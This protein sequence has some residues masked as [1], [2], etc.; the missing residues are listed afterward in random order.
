MKKGE[1]F[2]EQIIRET[3]SIKETG[4]INFSTVIE[5]VTGKKILSA[6]SKYLK[7]KL[8][9]LISC[10]DRVVKNSKENPI[11][12]GRINELG[13]AL[14]P[15]LKKQINLAGLNCSIPL[16]TSG[17]KQSSGYPD[18]IIENENKNIYIEVK[19]YAKKEG[20]LNS[21]FRSFYYEPKKETNKVNK[22]GYH[23]LV[24]FGHIG[25]DEDDTGY[26]LDSWH[27]VDLSKTKV[28]FKG[29]FQTN[30]KNMYRKENIIAKKL[31]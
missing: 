31:S 7:E 13:N 12:V 30:N 28:F 6:D 19:T 10:F 1:R 29:E 2:V 21:A 22:E 18:L 9:I 15:I 24:G 4:G 3:K 20:S 5:E 26:V 11:V 27:L 25:R 17:K 14:E 8:K 23:L 16:T